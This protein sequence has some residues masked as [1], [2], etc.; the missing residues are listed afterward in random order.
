MAGSHGLGFMEKGS[1]DSTMNVLI[2]GVV[3]L[4]AIAVFI[5]WGLDN[6]YPVPK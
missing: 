6:A 2:W 1:S 5:I 4:G 3:L